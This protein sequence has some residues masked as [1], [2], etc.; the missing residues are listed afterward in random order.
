MLSPF[1]KTSPS[2]RGVSL[3][4]ALRSRWTAKLGARQDDAD[5]EAPSYLGQFRSKRSGESI[6]RSAA[7]EA[8]NVVI[9]SILQCLEY[10][11]SDGREPG[12]QETSLSSEKRPS[13]GETLAEQWRKWHD[14]EHNCW[15]DPRWEPPEPSQPVEPLYNKLEEMLGGR[16]GYAEETPPKPRPDGLALPDLWKDWARDK[17]KIKYLEITGVGRSVTKLPNGRISAR[18]HHEE[19]EQKGRP[20]LVP[21]ETAEPSGETWIPVLLAGGWTTKIG[22]HGPGG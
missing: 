21:E 14:N 9:E 7:R 5:Y 20:Y 17:M 15:W 18:R 22:N 6:S 13:S 4:K 10:P 11:D 3:T 16:P 1:Q 2:S 19:Q 12:G 8:V